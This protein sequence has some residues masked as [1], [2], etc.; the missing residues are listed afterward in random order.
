MLMKI[1]TLLALAL[2]AFAV[3]C[4]TSSRQSSYAGTTHIAVSGASGAVLTGFYVQDGRRLAISN[5]VPWSS[6]VPRLSSLELRKA[7]PTE[8]VVVDLRYESDSPHAQIRK[9]LASGV[10]GM[11]V[12]VRDGLVATTF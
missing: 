6:D 11:H 9:P 5:A 2:T 3:G 12:E 1:F 8:A 4:A 10:V 7:H